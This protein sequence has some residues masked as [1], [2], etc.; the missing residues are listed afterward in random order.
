MWTEIT[1]GDFDYIA[2]ITIVQDI[3]NTWFGIVADCQFAKL[4]KNILAYSNP[5]TMAWKIITYHIWQI[6]AMIK[7]YFNL[8]KATIKWDPY[9]MGY[10]TGE[11][12]SNFFKWEIY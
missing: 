1:D 7:I 6:P 10:W 8:F 4:Y 2:I 5:L 12:I 9:Q 3:T 11:S